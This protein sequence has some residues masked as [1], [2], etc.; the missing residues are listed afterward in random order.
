LLQALPSSAQTWVG[1]RSTPNYGEIVA[2]DA[3]GEARWPYGSEDLAGDGA[4]FQQ[5]EQSIDVRTGY[6]ATTAQQLF[7]R[8]Y[9]SDTA[10]PGGNVALFVFVDT[11]RND[12]TGGSAAAAEIDARFTTDP[13]SG[14]YEYVIGIRGNSTIDGV[15][16]WQDAQNQFAPLTVSAADAVA[17]TGTDDDPIR[18]NGDTHGYLQATVD[19]ALVGL[20][21]AC[22]A[23]LYL[24]SL[25]DTA[26]IGDGDLDVGRAGSCIPTDANT[27][28]VPDVLTP[29]NGCTSDDQCA[30]DG[31]CVNGSCVFAPSCTATTDCGAGEECTSDGRCVPAPSGSCTSSDDCD[32]LICSGGQCTACDP[33]GTQCGAGRRCGPDGRCTAATSGGLAP[34]GGPLLAPDE[35]VQ[36]G[37]CACALSDRRMPRGLFTLFALPLFFVMRRRARTC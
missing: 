34:D 3:T 22:D 15:W 31:I 12:A 10:T 5:Q 35:E 32:R 25:N 2:I 9:V 11:D 6:A 24:R 28:G 36:G 20:S 16:Q 7:V 27:N 33:N 18:I 23:N 21:Q 1:G 29:P 17:D 37:A 19:L 14:G 26:A 4:A 8:G 30:A 13:S